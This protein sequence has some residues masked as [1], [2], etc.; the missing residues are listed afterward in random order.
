MFGFFI[1]LNWLFSALGALFGA[2][3]S[4]GGSLTAQRAQ[5]AAIRALTMREYARDQEFMATYR[6]RTKSFIRV[7]GV[8]MARLDAP[9]HIP[10]VQNLVDRFQVRRV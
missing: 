6:D 1:C 5:R 3:T 7:H 9:P 8:L 4:A 2:A 10:R